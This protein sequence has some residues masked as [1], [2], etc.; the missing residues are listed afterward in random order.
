MNHDMTT[1]AFTLDGYRI[2]KT[3]GVVP[4]VFDGMQ[5]RSNTVSE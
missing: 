3:K 1:T 5:F 4:Q 2:V